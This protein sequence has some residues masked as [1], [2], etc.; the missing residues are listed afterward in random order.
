MNQTMVEL[1]IDVK[2][3]PLGKLSKKQINKGY[4]ILKEVEDILSKPSSNTNAKLIDCSNR[5]Y[6]LIPHDFGFKLPAIINNKKVL[7]AKLEML[8]VPILIEIVS[9]LCRLWQISKSP[10]KFLKKN[11]TMS[12]K[13]LWTLNTRL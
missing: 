12:T 1:Q 13:I 5:F 9:N 3:M 2:K 6:T 7:E 4:E 8:E 10:V 11:Q